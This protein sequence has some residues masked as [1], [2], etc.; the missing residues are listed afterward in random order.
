MRKI[1]T[2]PVS[3]IEPYI[4]WIYFYHAWS[5][6]GKPREEKALLRKEAENVLHSWEGKVVLRA[7]FGLYDANSDGDDL[8]VGGVRIPMLR[9]QKADAQGAPNLCLADFVRPLSSGIKDRAGAFATTVDLVKVESLQDDPYR[10]MLL[11]TLSDRL[12]EGTAEK[13][14]EDVR[15]RYWGYAPH[16]HLT[17]QETH[18]E[19]Y[20]GIRPA[21][22]YPSLPDASVNFILG[23]LLGIKEIGIR[24]TESGMMVPHA[25]VSG[26]MFS[27]PKSR[28]FDVGKIGEDQLRDYARRRGLPIE[29]M[30]HFL[31]SSLLR[32]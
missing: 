19:K 17:I 4:N 6:D 15:R 3:E 12:A 20:Q 23:D 21:V 29:L 32:K 14:H 1:L 10:K 31:Q 8:L 5:L 16:E 11:Q 7:V 18:L 24:L 22:G 27:H 26:L 28:Y 13:M 25:S 9:Q 2:Y 30:R